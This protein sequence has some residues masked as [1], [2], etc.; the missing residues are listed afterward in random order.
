MVMSAYNLTGQEVKIL[1]DGLRPVNTSCIFSAWAKKAEAITISGYLQ[2]C[3][4]G[5]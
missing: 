4:C 1:Q 3:Y 5:R 2:E